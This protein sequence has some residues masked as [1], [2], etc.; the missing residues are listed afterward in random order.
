MNIH[1][2]KV[3]ISSCSCLSVNS[4]TID[5]PKPITNYFNDYFVDIAGKLVLNLP[6]IPHNF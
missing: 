3:K 5:D 4:I 1:L 2:G 6:Q